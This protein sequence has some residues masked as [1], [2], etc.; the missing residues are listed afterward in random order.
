MSRASA[1]IHRHSRASR[2][3]GASDVRR[4]LGPRF[5]AGLSGERNEVV[6]VL[7][8]TLLH[9]HGRACPG[10]PRLVD[11]R[12]KAWMPGT[13]PGMT[14]VVEQLFARTRLKG[15]NIFPG[16]PC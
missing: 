11:G 13:R 3:P 1:I 15:A 4:L 16:Q 6:N 2:N 9:R 14:V 5:R 12:K 8:K 10:H 7:P